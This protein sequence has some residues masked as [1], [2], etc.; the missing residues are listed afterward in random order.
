MS[1]IRKQSII[2]SIIIYFGFAIG[3][4]NIYFFTKEGV[5]ETEQ[6]GLT[7]VFVAIATMMMAFASLSMPSYILKFYPYYHDHLPVKKN[8]MLSWALLTSSIGFI[9][10]IIAGVAFKYVIIRKFSE[11]SPL[12]VNYYY[13]I[14]A[15][16]FGYT[17]YT[18]LEAYSWNLGKSVLTNFLKEVQWR[19][20]VTVL[21]VL[22]MAG[23][24]S[25]FSL[26]IKLYAFTYPAIA[27]MLLGYLLV[28]RKV[29]FTFTVSK[30]SRRYFKRIV[31]LCLFV[32]S[33]VL[34]FTITQV[35]DTLVIAAVLDE[36]LEKAGIFGLAQ[37]MTSVINAPQ[38]GVVAASVAHLSRAWKEKDMG[39]LQRIYHRSSINLLIF[40]SFLFALIA[41]NYTEAILTFDLQEKYLL[42]FHAFLLLG[43]TR[44]IDMG[45]GV[46][47]Q[48]I[49]TSTYWKFELICG[50]ILFVLMLPLT[51]ILTKEYDILGPAIANTISITIYNAIRIGFLWRKFNL[52][53]FRIQ[54]LYTVVLAAV[55]FVVCYYAFHSVHG[56]GGLVLRSAVFVALFG[57]AVIYFKL[58]PDVIPVWQTILK[59]MGLRPRD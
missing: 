44:I 10:V 25:D 12:L 16:G 26:F 2:S 31:R 42:G 6:Y 38:R 39:L 20:L 22:F 48:I 59:R 34:I 43:L 57:S 46:N 8:D 35:F 1:T 49:A 14:F 11:N 29:H 3:L 37:I 5:F 36:G 30:V 17:L 55:C 21:I 52:F 24:I 4:I 18:V 40:A 33:G 13:W 50:V 28:K 19:L 47:A 27:L 7:T 41:L 53:P 15:M 54:S 23:I 58:S 51:Y 32:Y 45:T 56:F 9:L